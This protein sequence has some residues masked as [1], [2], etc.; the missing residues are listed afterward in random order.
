[1]FLD[2]PDMRLPNL[3]NMVTVGQIRY[4]Q[5]VFE[6]PEHRNP[7]VVVREFLP[8]LQLWESRLRGRL[9]LGR[10]R[11]DPFYYY[12]LA[13]TKY[14]DA[15]FIDAVADRVDFIV[16]I[17][18]GCD[19]RAYRFA[20]VLQQRGIVAVE[21]DQP[22]AIVEKQRLAAERWPVD[23]VEYLPIDLNADGYP[24][25]GE[26]LRRNASARTLVLMEG[27]TPYVDAVAFGRFLDLLGTGLQAGNR[28]AYDF[29]VR[30]VADDFGRSARTRTPFRLPA[31]RAAVTEYHLAHR[32]ELEHL[33]LS[34]DLS[35][36][37]APSLSAGTPLFHEDALVRL[38]KC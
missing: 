13:R 16:H 14:Y 30:G 21:C 29:K 10:M 35:R 31:D 36:R 7:D 34:A 28:F 27:V 1:M 8:R 22:E 20:H 18:C 37:L 17:G 6:K 19:T 15:V 11:S 25:L 9:T 2:E 26:W 32:F 5:S 24:E 23:H 38:I 33:E 3:S 12:V 4:I